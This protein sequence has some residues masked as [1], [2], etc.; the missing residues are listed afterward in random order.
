MGP[1]EGPGKAAWP[2]WWWWGEAGG[3]AEHRPGGPGEDRSLGREHARQGERVGCSFGSSQQDLA[4]AGLC[5]RK[6]G[7]RS[8]SSRRSDLLGA[9]GSAFGEACHLSAVIICCDV[10]SAVL[11]CVTEKSLGAAGVEGPGLTA[12]TL[13]WRDRGWWWSDSRT[14]ALGAPAHGRSHALRRLAKGQPI[15]TS[16]R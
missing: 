6:P 9:R 11:I 10:E 2:G 3:P 12:G 4:A 5:S 14:S 16:Q 7:P 1:C 8:R 15:L 13:G